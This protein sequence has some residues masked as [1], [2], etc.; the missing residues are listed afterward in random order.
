MSLELSKYFQTHAEKAIA[1]MKAGVLAISYY[2]RIKWRLQHKEDLSGELPLIAKVG[3]AGTMAV[4]KEAIAD[5]QS[6]INTAW[7]LSPK[8]QEFVKQKITLIVNEREHLPRADVTYQFKSPAG[9]VKV[10][11]TTAG[12]TFKLG[13]NA[14]K[15]PMAAQM[16]CI[17]FEKQLSF[18]AL[19]T[20]TV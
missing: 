5:Y 3:P 16:A 8:L 11:I 15:N 7:N 17:E 12:E 10:R 1:K 14:G 4:V 13:I 18:I 9:V 19:T 2:E 6:Q 20:R